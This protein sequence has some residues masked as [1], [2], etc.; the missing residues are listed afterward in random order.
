[1]SPARQSGV[2]AWEEEI[3]P[4][5]HTLMI[6]QLTYPLAVKGFL[7]SLGQHWNLSFLGLAHFNACDLKDN[8]WLC[9]TCGSLGCGRQQFV[10]VSGNGHGLAHYKA[11]GP[12]VSVNLATITP[13]GGAGAKFLRFFI[14]F[15]QWLIQ[16]FIATCATT[17]EDPDVARHLASF[18][19]NVQTLTKT[20]K[21]M[22]ELVRPT[23]TSVVCSILTWQQQIEQ[24]LKYDFSLTGDDGKALEPVFGPG[25]TGLANLG[26]RQ[27]ILTDKSSFL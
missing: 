17:K 2:K 6:E 14:F 27:A 8:L 7:D 23:R 20:E 5:E 19:I 11:S 24:N 15:C 25:L 12:A 1:M 26:N 9:L 3:T 22:T 4:C 10:G 18:G 16:I 13:E 21:S